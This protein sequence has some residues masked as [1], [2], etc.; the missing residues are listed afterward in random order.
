MRRAFLPFIVLGSL[1]LAGCL[2]NPPRETAVAV[3]D[4]GSPRIATR[5]TSVRSGASGLSF[6]IVAGPGDGAGARPRLVPFTSATRVPVPKMPSSFFSP[7]VEKDG[8]GHVHAQA[9]GATQGKTKRVVSQMAKGFRGQP[10]QQSQLAAAE[11]ADELATG[12][13][14]VRALGDDGRSSLAPS[15]GASVV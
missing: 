9:Q 8:K 12:I 6:Q 4:L 15:H 14:Y 3:Y 11:S 7:D 10:Q 1:S 2:G 13:E 5:A